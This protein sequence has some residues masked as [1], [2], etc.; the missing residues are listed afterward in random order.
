MCFCSIFHVGSFSYYVMR[1]GQ[2]TKAYNARYWN[3]FELYFLR[4]KKLD[5]QHF[6]EN[7]YPVRAFMMLKILVKMEFENQTVS[8]LVRINNVK[9]HYSSHLFDLA[10]QTNVK[11]MNVKDKIHFYLLKHKM[12]KL[13]FALICMNNCKKMFW[14]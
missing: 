14:I 1:D 5:T 7:Q 3:N 12:I 4:F 8:P 2:A 11:S 13:Y 9:S 10:M 6:L